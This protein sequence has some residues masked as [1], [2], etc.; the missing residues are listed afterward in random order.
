[1]LAHGVNGKVRF[2]EVNHLAS[3]RRPVRA[4]GTLQYIKPATLIMTQSAPR[5]AVYRIVGNRLFVNGVHRGVPV[6]RYPGVVAI[7]SG[8]EGLLSGNYALLAHDF[9]THLTGDRKA[10]H[11]LLRPRL[12]SLKRA[13]SSVAISGRGPRLVEIETRAP[14]GDTSD[15]HILR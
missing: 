3:L 6:T 4:H 5:K 2:T 14:N 10:W 7:V 9:T 15:M 12:T 1:M 13:L 11:L 8:F